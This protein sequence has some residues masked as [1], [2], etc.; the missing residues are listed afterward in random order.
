MRQ[1]ADHASHGFSRQACI[2]VESNDE[3]N[4]GWHPGSRREHRRTSCHGATQQ[5][6]QFMQL[7][8]LALPAHPM[9]LALA[10]DAPAMQRIE[11]CAPR[12]SV[13]DAVEMRDTVGHQLQHRRV[14]GSVSRS[15]RRSNPEAAQMQLAVGRGQAVNFRVVRGNVSIASRVKSA[16]PGNNDHGAQVSWNAALRRISPITL[17]RRYRVNIVDARPKVGKE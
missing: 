17:L 15:P 7:A 12:G 3:T 6:V 4:V 13:V 14:F 5:L 16:A 2:G 8:S 1:L 10:P 11:A 9:L